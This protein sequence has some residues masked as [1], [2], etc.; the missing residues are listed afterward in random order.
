MKEV[1]IIRKGKMEEL[2]WLFIKF[3]NGELRGLKKWREVR[4]ENISLP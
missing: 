2:I 1:N 4:E 3:G